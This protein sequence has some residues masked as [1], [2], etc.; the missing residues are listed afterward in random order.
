MSLSEPPAPAGAGDS[1]LVD[2]HG[3]MSM[4][5][6]IPIE[7]SG[8]SESHSASASAERERERESIEEF[9][10]S[11]PTPS[12]NLEAAV[13]SSGD[14][15]NEARRGKAKANDWEYYNTL[16]RGIRENWPTT[17]R[18][19]RRIYRYFRGPSPPMPLPR[20][21]PVFHFNPLI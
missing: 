9:P 4:S 7:N 3:H 18:V 19:V 2:G 12:L 13:P 11:S 6:P 14:E 5:R 16:G 20:A 8:A 10:P 21:L 17:S 15:D 1:A